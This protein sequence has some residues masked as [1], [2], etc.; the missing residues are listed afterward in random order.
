MDLI[1]IIIPVYNVEKYISR[2]LDSLINQSYKNLEIILINDGSTDKSG[3]IC[4]SYS[5][6]YE[7]IYVYHKKNG[8]VSSARN[9]GLEKIN[10]NSK[11]I[12]FIDPDDFIDQDMYK[13]LYDNLIKYDAD[14]SICDME[15]VYNNN[16]YEKITNTND[17]KITNNIDVLEAFFYDIERYGVVWNKLY[18]RECIKDIKFDVVKS[19]EDIIY[20]QEAIYN[21]KKIVITNEKLYY[22]YQRKKSITKGGY[23]YFWEDFFYASERHIEFYKKINNR[24]LTG[25]AIERCLGIALGIFVDKYNSNSNDYRKW[26]QVYRLTLKKYIREIENYK[27]KIVYLL[28]YINPKI[29]I[30][31]SS[32]QNTGF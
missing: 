19:S 14:M 2:C 32:I 5:N 8:G 6:Q 11:F 7:N 26:K 1:S 25:L 3:E 24:Y 21:S 9:L 28:Y 20:S 31:K 12:G 18:K 10:I 17:E 13:I 27:L 22:Y 16:D 4:D 15:K 30:R 29:Y 23:K